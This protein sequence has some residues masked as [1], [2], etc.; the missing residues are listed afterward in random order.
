ML[1]GVWKSLWRTHEIRT[2]F[3]HPEMEK[4]VFL[5]FHIRK[6][7]QNGWPILG[8]VDF[9]TFLHSLLLLSFLN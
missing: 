1:N 5:I 6:S 7:D 3:L 4:W 8:K 2:F 9:P